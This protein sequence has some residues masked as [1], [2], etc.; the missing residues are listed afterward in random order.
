VWTYLPSHV[1]FSDVNIVL[2]LCCE[3]QLGQDIPQLL[4]YPCP[5]QLCL[6]W[7]SRHWQ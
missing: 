6:V 4:I 3:L 2:W 5:T 1:I 7:V